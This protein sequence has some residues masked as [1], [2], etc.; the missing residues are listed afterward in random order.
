VWY[1]YKGCEFVENFATFPYKAM[2]LTL[3]KE[4]EYNN[5]EDVYEELCR[6]YDKSFNKF[7]IGESLFVSHLFYA[8]P[9]NF[10]NNK[11]QNRIKKVQYSLESKTPLYATVQD[12]P[13]SV[14][15]EF[16]LYKSESE[17]CIQYLATERK[18]KHGDKK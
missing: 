6:C 14:V 16:L 3:N 17:H 5:I 12:T 9:T 11:I 13:A 4:I 2:S 10:Y 7:P 1:Y 15:N 18:K 8:N